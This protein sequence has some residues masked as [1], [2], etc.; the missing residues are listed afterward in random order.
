MT[1]HNP[2]GYFKSS[3]EVIRLVGMMGFVRRK[4]LE[5]ALSEENRALTI[6]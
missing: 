6:F 1:K 3:P 4:W 5:G 2:F